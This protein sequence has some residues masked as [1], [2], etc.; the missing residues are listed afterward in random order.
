LQG[1]ASFGIAIYPADACTRDSLLNAAD[2]AM[3]AAKQSK[4][5]IANPQAVP[6]C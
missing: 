2:S 6:S 5:T 3:Y 4:Q 1:S